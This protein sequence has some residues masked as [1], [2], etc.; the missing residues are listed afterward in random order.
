[1]V[2]VGGFELDRPQRLHEAAR[3]AQVAYGEV[4]EGAARLGAEEG[5]S[6]DLDLPIESRS[7]RCGV[8]C[9]DMVPP[10]R[11]RTFR[12]I[13]C[14]NHRRRFIASREAVNAETRDVEGVAHTDVRVSGV[15]LWG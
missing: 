6:R 4:V 1:M 11:S 14:S 10:V 2:D 5:V 8:S 15:N 3:L 9:W 7:T 13:L 12:T